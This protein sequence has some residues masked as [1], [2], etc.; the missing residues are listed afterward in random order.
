MKMINYSKHLMQTMELLQ[1]HLMYM[2]ENNFR[3][4][5]F[6]DIKWKSIFSSI[7]SKRVHKKL[8]KIDNAFIY[9]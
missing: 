3:S 7:Y 8:H 4:Y 1:F 2:L 6:N 5:T 9:M